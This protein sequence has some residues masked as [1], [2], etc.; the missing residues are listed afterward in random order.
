MYLYVIH[1]SAQHAADMYNFYNA[2]AYE[3]KVHGLWL[4]VVGLYLDPN[5][6]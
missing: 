6:M 5:S 1:A 2:K 3:L 4:R